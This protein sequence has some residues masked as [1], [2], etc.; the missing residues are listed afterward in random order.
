[1]KNEDN[2]VYL[3]EINVASMLPFGSMLRPLLNDSCLNDADL[4]NIFKSRGVFVGD[5]D[6]RNT[7]PLMVTMILSPKEFEMLQ[8][9]QET[10]EDNPKHRNSV[11]KSSSKNSLTSIISEFQIN[12]DE[13]EKI[14]DDVHLNSPMV[15]GYVSK[16]HLELEYSIIREDLTKDW[17][18]PQSSHSAKVIIIKDEA[19]GEIGICNEY[20]SKETDD[21]NKKVI[22]DV[23]SFFKSKGEAEDTLETICANDFT[24]RERF[25]FMLRLAAD[26]EDNSL[27]FIE[28][29]DVE[30]GPDPDN[31]PKNPNSIIQQNVKKIIIN[32]NGLERNTLLTDDKDKDNL[33]LRS[34]E[35]AYNFNCNGVK[36]RCVLQY[37]FM[38][39]FR[40]QSG[41][42]NMS[43]EFQVA[44]L[45]L[46]A[47]SGNKTSLNNFVLNKFESLKRKQYETFKS[48]K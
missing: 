1:M 41:N 4:N 38:H 44:L 13:I 29:R 45:F 6:K 22:K 10:K 15:F 23:V 12:T 48:S 42:K 43:Q 2:I 11:I 33:L 30:I 9:K 26:I 32:G 7:I 19:Q 21:I 36:G 3:P 47:K 40:N 16:N 17:V 25:N 34:I 5:S 18:R 27:E 8:E 39:F 31:P 24:N 46:Y 35:A 37:G 28:I 20:T 14:N